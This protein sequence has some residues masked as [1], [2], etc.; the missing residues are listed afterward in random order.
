V[1]RARDARA[2]LRHATTALLL[3]REPAQNGEITAVLEGPER[4]SYVR[5]KVVIVASGGHD[6]QP[7][8]GN[9]DL[10]GVFSARAALQLLHAGI[11]LGKRVAL[12]GD[13]RF[14]RSFAEA[15]RQI[16][17]FRFEA[18]RVE[19]AKGQHAV[20]RLLYEEGG[21]SRELVV[22]AIAVDGPHAPAVELLGQLGGQVRFDPARGYLPEL[23]AEGRAGEAVFAAGSCAASPRSSEEDGARVARAV[24]NSTR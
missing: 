15:R 18:K 20:T 13:G 16:G 10:P 4:A 7:S 22:N 23:D 3:S 6:A 8:F 21:K 12:V 17:V 11:S 5:C 24:I 1:H 19:R 2:E 9:N 14:A